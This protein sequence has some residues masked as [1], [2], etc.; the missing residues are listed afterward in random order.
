M[1]SN[2]SDR[3]EDVDT[4]SLLEKRPYIQR[5]GTGSRIN[6][7]I[8]TASLALNAIFL[9]L[10]SVFAFKAHKPSYEA[11]FDSDLLGVRSQIRITKQRFSGGVELDQ[12]GHFTVDPSGSQYVGDPSPEVDRAWVE[13]LNGLNL[14]LDATEY[15]PAGKTYQWEE[16]GLYFTGLE[17]YHSLH[18]LNRL[19]QALYPD[20]YKTVFNHTG[21]PSRQDHIGHCINQLREALQC[22]ADLTP[23][24]WK[25][26]G[27]KIILNTATEHQCRDFDQIHA[28]AKERQTQFINIPA[29]LNG[30][31]LVVD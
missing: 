26:V 10:L 23:M 15:D 21:D 22:H 31:L 4:A 5:K 20:Y 12:H 1:A 19:R 24:E 7:I 8:L 6:F 18:C 25:R 27:D 14:D 13:L 16:S 2:D 11:G 30:S 29:I 28:W 3:D 9:G 17:V